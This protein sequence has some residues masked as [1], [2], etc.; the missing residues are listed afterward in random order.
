MSLMKQIFQYSLRDLIKTHQYPLSVTPT[1]ATLEL[2]D[3]KRESSL[4]L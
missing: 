1:K 4:G 3:I 2:T